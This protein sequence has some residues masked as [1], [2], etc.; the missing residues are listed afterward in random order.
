MYY[1]DGNSHDQFKAIDIE[2]EL[3]YCLALITLPVHHLFQGLLSLGKVIRALTSNPIQH[4]PYR[5]SKLTRFLQD[6]LGGNSRTVM[7]ACISSAECNLHET[8]GTLQY[9]YRAKAVQNK[10][11]ANI[12]VGVIPQAGSEF[13]TEMESSVIV[14]LRAQ[15]AQMQQEMT[16]FHA[17][18]HPHQQ[19]I[20][21][22]DY[23]ATGGTAGSDPRS[24]RALE[25]AREEAEAAGKQ[26]QRI[27]RVAG[28]I[29]LTMREHLR[30][31][32]NTGSN[33][34]EACGP[35][36]N[37]I[38]VCHTVVRTLEELQQQ[39]L[40][41]SSLASATSLRRSTS[42]LR[43]SLNESISG[44]TGGARVVPDL[45]EEVSALR[46]ELEE[47]REDLK[48]DEDI[49]AEKIK[50]LKRCRK[51]IKELEVENKSLA[52][53]HQTAQAQVQKLAGNLLNQ[54]RHPASSKNN[55]ADTTIDGAGGVDDLDISVAVAVNEPDISQLM[56]DLETMA[57][58]KEDLLA[59]NMLAEEKVATAWSS[60][61]NQ[62]EE[63]IQGQAALKEK[64]AELETNIRNKERTI[65]ELTQAQSR[66]FREA[67]L[68]QER[69][70]EVELEG[71][72]LREQLHALDDARQKSAEEISEE[73]VKRREYEAKLRQAEEQLVAME[74]E[75]KSFMEDERRRIQSEEKSNFENKK[76]TEHLLELETFRSEYARLTAQIE[77]T[78][79]RQRKT[80]DQLTHQVTQF[81]KKAADSQQQIRALEEK[82]VDLRNRLERFAKA[83]RKNGFE[84]PDEPDST[85]G[86]K[87]E[88][89][90]ASGPGGAGAGPRSES[91]Y[92][93]SKGEDLPPPTAGAGKRAAATVR[94]PEEASITPAA[95]SELVRTKVED[96][97]E[98]RLA[99]SELER[100]ERANVNLKAER[101]DILAELRPIQTKQ[102]EAEGK[103]RK[104]MSEIDNKIVA[105]QE[106]TAALQRRYDAAL[107]KGA[108]TSALHDEIEN[109]QE[110]IGTYEDHKREYEDRL[111]RGGLDDALLNQKQDLQEEL[112]TLDTEVELN[113]ARMAHEKLR[114]HKLEDS[115]LGVKPASSL[116]STRPRTTAAISQEDCYQALLSNL[117]ASLYMDNPSAE[118]RLDAAF[119]QV[120]EMLVQHR[121]QG[122]DSSALLKQVQQ[123]LDDKSAEYEELVRNMQKSRSEAMRRQEQQK[124][125]AEDKIAFLLQQL[126]TAESRRVHDD[127]SSQ[128][129]PSTPASS[130]NRG[131]SSTAQSTPDHQPARGAGSHESASQSA[132]SSS[133]ARPQSAN[134]TAAGGSSGVPSRGLTSGGVRT[135]VSA[136]S[137]RPPSD[138][139]LS[140][141]VRLA[142]GDVNRELERRWLGE[143]E[144]REQLEKR[145][146]E[147]ARELRQL[148]AAGAGGGG[149][150]KL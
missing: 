59:D 62:K 50:E 57:R 73:R 9:A 111:Q 72:R 94:E 93:Q 123:Q 120:V 7:L 101:E 114:L 86:A 71:R 54:Q 46:A 133:A 19:G 139:M 70:R 138:A 56:E 68:Y 112:E 116:S 58:E 11:S 41:L 60:A 122:T 144:R 97:I 2:R 37:L 126:R 105:L 150:A 22:S 125:E 23:D 124:R 26:L 135:S 118:A 88:G 79:N 17:T 65:E 115:V 3:S 28:R 5:E 31:L 15:I 10:L 13:A 102:A 49:F 128:A 130:K 61:R 66:A 29:Q 140:E 42:A 98:Y 18:S 81:K 6:S 91:K 99:R 48:R 117:K 104:K 106:R 90:P 108:D 142:P 35:A 96:I 107:S 67:E 119:K 92:A 131:F 36:W 113:Q 149:D 53:K 141:L 14:S 1:V 87:G 95:L 30:H 137:A 75:R 43:S 83:R 40:P 4:V 39:G 64:L 80:L 21:L 132:S 76:A 20:A 33:N 52:E 148:R 121:T 25:A 136:G 24:D 134:Y 77:L 16:Q 12:S 89:A 103:L 100:L 146:V 145:T 78:E 127:S 84:D 69:T 82:N 63:F 51:K 44:F 110:S 34:A 85:A 8:L 32:E 74:R 55:R 45:A 109:L 143:K 47:C 129:G 27:L 38:N 147:M